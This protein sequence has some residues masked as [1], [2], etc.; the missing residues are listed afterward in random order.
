MAR[1]CAL[2]DA[3]LSWKEEQLRVRQELKAA[4]VTAYGRLKFASKFLPHVLHPD[5][6]VR[7]AVY[8][9]YTEGTGLMRW[10]EGLLV[11][12]DRRLIFLDRKPGFESMDE[13]TYD[14]VSGVKKTYAWPFAAIMLHTKLGNYSL[15]FANMRCIDTFIRYVEQRRLEYF[16]GMLNVRQ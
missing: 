10:T 13:L 1:A 7:A 5:E 15:R 16:N 4:G 12:T 14:I 8:G 6:H 2:S 9:R 11:A 3:H